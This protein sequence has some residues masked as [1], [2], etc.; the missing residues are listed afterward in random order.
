MAKATSKQTSPSRQPVHEMI[1]NHILRGIR[2][3]T[4]VPGQKVEIVDEMVKRS[5]ASRAS[6]Q[7]S[8]LLLASKGLIS[9]RPRAG[10]FIS[11]DALNVVERRTESQSVALIVPGIDGMEFASLARG[12]ENA[13]HSHKLNVIV[14]ST[15][16]SL[17]RY[18][19]ILQR[20]I[21]SNVFGIF[22]VPPLGHRLS[23]SILQKLQ[24]SGIPVVTCFR[25]LYEITGWPV[26][27]VNGYATTYAAAAH[28]AS[29]KRRNIGFF[30]FISPPGTII[31]ESNYLGFIHALLDNGVRLT[32]NCRGRFGGP[33]LY[34]DT[35]FDNSNEAPIRKEMERWLDEHPGTDAICCNHDLLASIAIRVLKRRGKR[36]PED[37]AVSGEG[38]YSRHLGIPSGEM[39]TTRMI[40]EEFGHEFCRIVLQL[41]SGN[42]D[43]APVT[44]IASALIP[45]RSTIGNA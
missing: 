43:V 5:G 39:T 28:L 10:T 33:E 18:E 7:Q 1:E 36:V 45:G 41:R 42:T 40:Y 16:N 11:D 37:V 8:M 19:E 25:S 13:A 44:E 29:L 31:D 3:G 35:G 27:R 22:M 17:E 14:S 6:V 23:L 24:Q 9:R 2:D 4:L 38:D 15:D 12:V 30:N 32:S 21:D 26:I 20:N 34:Y